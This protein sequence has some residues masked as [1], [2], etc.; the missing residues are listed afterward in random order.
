MGRALDGLDF[1]EKDFLE[2]S[3]QKPKNPK[4]PKKQWTLLFLGTFF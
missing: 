1:L 4:P 2:K 3:P